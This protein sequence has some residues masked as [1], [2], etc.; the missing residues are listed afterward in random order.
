MYFRAIINHFNPKIESYAAVNHISQL[1]EEQVG[2]TPDMDI[3]SLSRLLRLNMRE[4]RVS[5]VGSLGLRRFQ[6]V[7]PRAGYGERD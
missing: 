6:K 4:T 7:T 5:G 2:T 1:S 3:F